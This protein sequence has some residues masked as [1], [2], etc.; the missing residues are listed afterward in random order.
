MKVNRY[1]CKLCGYIYS[2]MRGEPRRGIPEGTE[3][4]DLPDEYKCPVC[5]AAGKGKIGKWGF[6]LFIP[7]RYRCRLCGYIYDK[8]RGEPHRGIP[9][10]TSFEDL[11]ED[12]ICPVC[13]M[14][15]RITD[16]YGKV[17]KQQFEPLDI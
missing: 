8:K 2:P 15:Q 11:P 16:Y 17:L 13:F 5:G 14:D 7:T 6:D 1:R 10:G 9:A 4:E 12:Y 3:F